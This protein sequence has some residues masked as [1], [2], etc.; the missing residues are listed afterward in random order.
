[1]S[2]KYTRRRFLYSGAAATSVGLA[3]C[4]DRGTGSE[5]TTSAAQSEQPPPDVPTEQFDPADGRRALQALLDEYGADPVVVRI[6][7]GVLTVDTNVVI[8]SNTL[9]R[10]AGRETRFRYADGADLDV[11][12]LL[13]LNRSANVTIAD[14]RVDG[15]RANVTD[16]GEEYGVYTRS[17]RNVRFERVTVHDCPGYGFDP[18]DSEHGPTEQLAIVDCEAFGNGLDGFTLAGIREGYVV[19]CHAHDNDR[20]GV[21]LTD[22][23]VRGIAVRETRCL[24]NGASGIAVQNDATGIAL[25]GNELRRNGERGIRVGA[26]DSSARDCAVVGNAIDGNEGGVHVLTAERVAIAGNRF[27]AT[28]GGD[29]WS[30][31]VLAETTGGG[32]RDCVVLGNAAASGRQ[33]SVEDRVGSNFVAVNAQGEAIP[34]FT[35]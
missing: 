8:P 17:A 20:H 3:G 23:A 24:D 18:H 15:N 25:R 19:G 9:F 16:N 34:G 7:P 35:G 29:E 22:Q 5:P 33:L 1:M 26:T 14:L 12:G 30:D 6:G 32:A 13:R 2:Q 11:A 27:G 10:G 4:G 21:N 31:V 28:A